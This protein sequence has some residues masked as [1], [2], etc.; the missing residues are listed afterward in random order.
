MYTDTI[1]VF[2]LF[3]WKIVMGY[4][5]VFSIFLFFIRCISCKKRLFVASILGYVLVFDT[6]FMQL[7]MMQKGHWHADS[8]LPFYYCNIMAI[9]AA[10]ALIMRNQKVYEISL[11]LGFLAPLQGILTPGFGNGL[12][13]Y[14]PYSYFLSHG[15]TVLAPIYLTLCLGF[16]P[17]RGA[18]WKAPLYVYWLALPLYLLNCWLDANYS[19][20]SKKPEIDHVLNIAPWPFYLFLWTGAL[21]LSG[22]CIERS[23]LFVCYRRAKRSPKTSFDDTIS[24]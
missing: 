22:Y 20:L 9:F 4:L 8:S 16:R 17:R 7:Y 2:S 6:L 18:W 10:A 5:L 14:Y 21:M 13:G 11:Y 3:W 23:V 1:A 15:I 24:S 19:F 12:A